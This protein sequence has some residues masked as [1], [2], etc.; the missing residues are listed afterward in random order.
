MLK[1]IR[2]CLGTMNFGPQTAEGDSHAI[3]DRA[4][5]HGINFFD[6]AD[7][8]GWK[9]GEGWTEQIIGRWFAQGGGRREKVVLATK[10]YNKMGEWPNESALSALPIRVAR[11]HPAASQTDHMIYQM[12][13]I[14][15]APRKIGSDEQLVR[16]AS[17]LHGAATRGGHIARRRE[18]PGPTL[19]GLVSA[20]SLTPER[21]HGGAEVP[22]GVP[23]LRPRAH[24]ADALAPACW[25]P[26][27]EDRR[28]PGGRLRTCRRS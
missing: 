27:A 6:T 17:P 23:G 26:S 1:V 25:A 4:L 5:E 15:R 11:T 22:S 13:H 12:H 19:H 18:R 24:R 21:P 16:R 14:T 20:Q 9:M 28:R 2:L 8:Y 7:V 10:L 3:M